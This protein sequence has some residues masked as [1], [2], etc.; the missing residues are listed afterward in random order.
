[1]SVELDDIVVQ[2]VTDLGLSPWL[3]IAYRYTATGRDPRSGAGARAIGGRWNPLNMFSAIY[4]A[5]S[6]T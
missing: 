4:L 5:E 3:G 1:M 2:R 6:V